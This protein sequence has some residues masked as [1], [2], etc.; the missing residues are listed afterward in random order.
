MN[1]ELTSVSHGSH[2]D[3]HD[4]HDSYDLHDSLARSL[5][6]PGSPLVE[7]FKVL[8]WFISAR[9][10]LKIYGLIYLLLR[11]LILVRNHLSSWPQKAS[12][13]G[14]KAGLLSSSSI[15]CQNTCII[16]FLSN[17]M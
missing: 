7:L 16:K 17:T 10:W 11:E 6:R 13:R 5:S 1:W 3:S 14:M 12:L 15:T 2:D 8:F 4:S 9:V